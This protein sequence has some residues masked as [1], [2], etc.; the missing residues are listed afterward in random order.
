VLSKVFS[1][2]GRGRELFAAVERLDLEG[3]VA[4]QRLD[5]SAADTVWFKVKNRAYTQMEGRGD[6]F[7]PTRR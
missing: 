7:H 5:P 4:K 2:R 3:L 1:V 6:L